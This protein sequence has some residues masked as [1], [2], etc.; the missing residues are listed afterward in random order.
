MIASGEWWCVSIWKSFPFSLHLVRKNVNKNKQVNTKSPWGCQ[1]M[2]VVT[3]YPCAI[4]PYTVANLNVS[5]FSKFILE[6]EYELEVMRDFWCKEINSGFVSFCSL[7]CPRGWGVGDVCKT[8]ELHKENCQGLNSCFWYITL[9]RDNK[10]NSI[11]VTF[12]SLEKITSSDL[13]LGLGLGLRL[14][15][16]TELGLRVDF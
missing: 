7:S 2:S 5:G 6:V 15:L 4:N 1:R 12:R 13:K 16:G 8:I 9:G 3:V 11:K 10:V 14:E